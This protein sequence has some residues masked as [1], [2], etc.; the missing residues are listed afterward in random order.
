MDFEE[1]YLKKYRRKE[2][3]K[4]N[5]SSSSSEVRFFMALSTCFML[6]SLALPAFL[7]FNALVIAICSIKADF[8][9]PGI[10]KEISLK[11]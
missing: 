3:I 4:N 10:F 8:S 6:N 7:S 5:Y 9:L 2:I 11:R 1:K